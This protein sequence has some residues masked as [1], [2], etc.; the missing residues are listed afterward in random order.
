MSRIHPFDVVSAGLPEE[1]FS[2][3]RATEAQGRDPT[4]RLQFHELAPVR[5]ILRPLSSPGAEATATTI[6]QYE[7]LLYA[8]Y[9]FWSAGRHSAALGRE[10]LGHAL[11]AAGPTGVAGRP[12]PVPHGACY[13]QVPE[14][15]FWARIDDT[16]PPE[17]LDGL[18]LATGVGSREM[19]ILAVLGLRP[20]RDGFSQIAVAVP[21]EDL[22]HAAEFARRPLFA[23]VLEG[24]DRAGV[25]SLVSEAELLHLTH[26]ALAEVAR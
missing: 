21:P 19:T 16:A 2:D 17:P 8:A 10:R 5:D 15:L 26:L 25:K 9:R 1:W 24:G 20:E 18:F 3:V 11:A 6:A 23:P 13:V 4:D 22:A 12:L 14:R 7:T